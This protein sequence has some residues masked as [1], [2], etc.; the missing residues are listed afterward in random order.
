MKEVFFVV[1]G[2]EI[3]NKV[4][5]FTTNDQGHGVHLADIA[6]TENDILLSRR[7]DGLQETAI[8]LGPPCPQAK[9]A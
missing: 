7:S 1:G 2:R 6:P 5:I 3:K 8:P 4:Q 9:S